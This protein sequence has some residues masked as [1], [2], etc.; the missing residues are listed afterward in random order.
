[1]SDSSEY[2]D[3]LLSDWE[4]WRV[5]LGAIAVTIGA[6]GAAGGG[7]GGGGL[8]VPLLMIVIGFDAKEA[9]PVSQG[10]IVGA[11]I[12]HLILNAPKRHPLKEIPV[13]DYAALLVLEPM[14]LTG[15]IFGVMLNGMLPSI[16]ILIIL[17]VVLSA[18]AWKTAKRAKRITANERKRISQERARG[19]GEK[20]AYDTTKVGVENPGM[21]GLPIADKHEELVEVRPSVARMSGRQYIMW[22][23]LGIVLLLWVIV[24]VSVMIRGSS[25]GDYSIAGIYY[26]SAAFWGLTIAIPAIEIGFSLFFG[27]LEIDR[28]KNSPAEEISELMQGEK[29]QLEDYKEVDWN[30]NNVFRYMFFAFV[31][32][33]LAGCLGIGGGLV[34]SPLLLELGFYPAVASAISGMAVLVTSTSSLF[35]YGLSDKVYWEF[36]G[37]LM[38][39]TFLATLVGKILIDSYA[40]R[41]RKQSVIIWSVA[42]FLI[43]CLI[44]LTAKG[45]ADLLTNP[46]YDFSSPCDS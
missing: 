13:V 19:I 23:K 44:M 2:S 18:G 38:P 32:G 46:D 40:E 9:V 21:Q 27:K 20:V 33:V 42:I 29:A 15:S 17:V 24:S 10:C 16:A 35:V 6:T 26:C 34:L 30:W 3:P 45:I 12:A 22:R 7:I 39:F 14:L 43:C 1:M 28:Q 31:C 41:N 11:A 8:Y 25:S 37:L 5:V 4:T 36:V